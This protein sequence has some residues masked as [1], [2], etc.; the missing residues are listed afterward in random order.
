MHVLFVSAPVD[1]TM[2]GLFEDDDEAEDAVISQV[3]IA[4]YMC[5]MVGVCMVWQ[6]NCI[7][8]CVHFVV[9]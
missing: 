1:D 2:E 4:K 5:N 3:Y 7:Y 6:A 9:S 8:L